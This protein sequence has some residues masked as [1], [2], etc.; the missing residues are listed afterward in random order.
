MT[1]NVRDIIGF[2]IIG[3][4]AGVM[5]LYLLLPP[6]LDDSQAAVQNMLI[7]ALIGSTTTVIGFHFGSSSGSKDKDDALIAATEVRTTNGEK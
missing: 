2:C 4:F 3:I 7:G 6:V 1:F 5:F